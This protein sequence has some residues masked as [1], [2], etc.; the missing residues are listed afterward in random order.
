MICNKCGKTLPDDS[1]FCQF[2]GSEI[3]IA[4]ADVASDPKP[5]I[6]KE[7][8]MAT[9]LAEMSAREQKDGYANTE[10]QP[11][12]ETE[13]PIGITP[14]K[15]VNKKLVVCLT[16]IPT[17]IL[18]VT[19]LVVFLLIPGLKYNHA[20]KLLENGKYE[21]AYSEFLALGDFSNSQEMLLECR[22]AQAVKY[23]DAGD[24]E[25][26][27]KIF[28]S[29]GNYRDSKILIHKHDYRVISRTEATCTEDGNE[30]FECSG[31]K[32]SYTNYLK[33]SHK[34]VVTKTTDATCTATGSKIYECSSCHNTY[35]EI[36]SLKSHSYSSATCTK[37]KKCSTCG[38]TEGT[39][40]GHTTSGV[41]CTRCG[42][43]TFKTLTYSGTGSKVIKDINVPK[44]TFLITGYATSTDGWIGS[45]YVYLNHANGYDAAYWIDS[46]N[47]YLE[48][49]EGF[50]G[51]ISGGY[52]EVKADS[53]IKWKITIEAV[54][55]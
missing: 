45:F 19:L 4:T 27:N 54:S 13:S 2:C 7:D 10:H 53:N 9:I 14:K 47:S 22:Y 3:E 29:L 38:K 46:T 44:G 11:Q 17:L 6:S 51:S 50:S 52:I 15:P 25:L 31:C 26:A 41:K 24:Y 5:S 32:D 40:L 23:R 12:N 20:K 21:L 30:V 8:V 34:Y 37:A 39:A 28:E 1:T 18:L 42:E 48:K 43:V 36:I 35:S 55:N 49:A 33:A 16:V